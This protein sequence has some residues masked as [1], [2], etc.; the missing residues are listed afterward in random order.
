M[1]HPL[2]ASL[3]LVG[4]LVPD[5]AHAQSKVGTTILQFLK[6][7]PGARSAG[8]G[9]AGSALAEG[10]DCVYFNPGTIGSLTRTEVTFTHSA[11]FA[12]IDFDYAAVALPLGGQGAVLASVTALSS[13]EIPVRTVDAPLGTGERYTVSDVAITLGYGRQITSRFAAGVQARYVTEQIWNSSVHAVTFDLGTVYRLSE[14]GLQMGF[15]LAN[16]GTRSDF[17]GRDLAIQYDA[18]PDVYGDNSALPGYQ[19]TDSYMVPLLMRLGLSYPYVVSKDTLLLLAIEALHPNDNSESV[20]A[21]MEW[22][23]R[24][25]L[26]LR[27][28]YQTLFDSNSDLGLTAG[29]G[30]Q[31]DIARS[32]CRLDYAWTDHDRLGSTQRITVVFQF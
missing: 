13:G 1:K 22:S 32:R 7:E 8:M 31:T 12:D 10:I 25:T 24:K 16:L 23:W 5:G 30:L 29:F 26:A 15:G 17:D 21:G 19:A 14:D 18:D 4:L 11:W 6:I 9:N 2:L 28:G 20:N 27:A 3:L